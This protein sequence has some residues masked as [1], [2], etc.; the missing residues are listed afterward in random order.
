MEPKR[1]PKPNNKPKSESKRKHPGHVM[2][3]D[4]FRERLMED[5]GYEHYEN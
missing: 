1:K 4:E 3:K 5:L 2:T